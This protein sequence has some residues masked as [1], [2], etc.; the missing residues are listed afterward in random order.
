MRPRH[1]TPTATRAQRAIRPERP[2]RPVG[3]AE[4]RPVAGRTAPPRAPGAWRPSAHCA[5]TTATQWAARAL[6]PSAHRPPAA[7]AWTATA[8]TAT[9]W[10]ATAGTAD[11]GLAG[12][13]WVVLPRRPRSEAERISCRWGRSGA[14][15]RPGVAR[16]RGAQRRPVALSEAKRVASEARSAARPDPTAVAP[17]GG[18]PSAQRAVP[19]PPAPANAARVRTAARPPVARRAGLGVVNLECFPVM[20]SPGLEPGRRGPGRRPPG[21]A[22][23]G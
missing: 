18:L 1:L 3:T 6:R 20:S 22:S 19:G 8:W 5:W 10:T 23:P 11:A 4:F 15:G 2:E 9:A 21:W 7:V 16:R 17:R 13:S 12:T 14:E